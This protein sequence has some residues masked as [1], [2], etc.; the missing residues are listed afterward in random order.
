MLRL[1]THRYANK[2]NNGRA[3]KDRVCFAFFCGLNWDVEFWPIRLKRG[4][5]LGDSSV[6]GYDIYNFLYSV[7]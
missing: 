2:Q 3:A 1:V 6:I 5:I 7:V 4:M